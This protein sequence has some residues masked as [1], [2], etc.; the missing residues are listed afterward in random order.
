MDMS[1]YKILEN[2][3]FPTYLE[4]GGAKHIVNYDEQDITLY[5][6]FDNLGTEVRPKEN[7]KFDPKPPP[8]KEKK[9]LPTPKPKKEVEEGEEGENAEDV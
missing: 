6:I 5:E 2:Y 3:D 8:P 9:K 7:P 1:K 4:K